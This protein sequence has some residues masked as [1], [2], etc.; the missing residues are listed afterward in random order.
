MTD[1]SGM[2]Q[3]LAEQLEPNLIEE[4]L[5]AVQNIQDSIEMAKLVEAILQGDVERALSLLDLDSKYFWPLREAIRTTFNVAGETTLS[6]LGSTAA[7]GSKGFRLSARWEG[8]NPRAAW[9]ASTRSSKLVTSI[10][11]DQKDELRQVLLRAFE[12]KQPPA[13]IALEI[14]GRVNKATG[15]REGGFIGLHSGQIRLSNKVRDRFSIARPDWT[16]YKTLESR[17]KRLDSIVRKAWEEGHTLSQA[18]IDKIV[19]AMENKMLKQRGETIARTEA[20]A[21]VHKGQWEAMEQ[22]IESGVLARDQVI[23]VWSATMDKR[24][25]DS[26]RE[27]DKTQKPFLEPFISPST[28]AAMM[29]PGDFDHGASGEDV[30]NCR[31]YMH[32]RVDW[33]RGLT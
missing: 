29:H 32:I 7:R 6:T 30:V 22:Q 25:R 24:T 5:R 16:W 13:K 20:L 19:T 8:D 15:R 4:F 17:D 14:V 23:K 18:Q 12:K 21:A 3:Q 27:L 26:H 1:N 11:D 2:V 33:M 31:C 9:W 10:I 28:G